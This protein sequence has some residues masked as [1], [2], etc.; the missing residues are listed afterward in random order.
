LSYALGG[1]MEGSLRRQQEDIGGCMIFFPPKRILV[2]YDLSDASRLAWQHAV[3]LAGRCGALLEIVHVDPWEPSGDL[4]PLPDVT[5]MRI[6]AIRAQIR[7]VVGEGTKITILQGDPTAGILGLARTRRAGL[8]VV[9][10]HGRSGFKKALLG[11]V[12]EAVIHSSS[13]PVLA[14]RGPVK[15]IRSILVPVNFTNY[16]EYGLAYA[17]GAASALKTG[18]TALHVDEESAGIGNSQLR[19]YKLLHRLP[20]EIRRNCRPKAEAAYGDVTEAILKEER[21]H[22]WLIMV[23]HKKAFVADALFGTTVE[24]MFCRSSIPI[25]AV[26]TPRRPFTFGKSNRSSVSGRTLIVR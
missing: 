20:L 18:L 26:P 23:A 13:V 6:R 22:D 2:A 14:V 17:A 4:V 7:A 24:K 9:G 10:T 12:A 8:I 3:A 11:S 25:L 15:P 16:S 5:P 19:L 1:V 21:A